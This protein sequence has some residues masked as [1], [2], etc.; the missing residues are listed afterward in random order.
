MPN[1][2]KL[3]LLLYV[4]LIFTSSKVWALA[5]EA[6]GQARWDKANPIL[7][8][9]QALQH[10]TDQIRQKAADY[11]TSQHR[12]RLTRSGPQGHDSLDVYPTGA[13]N[14]VRVIEE[15]IKKK[16]LYLTVVGDIELYMDC[17]E[18]KRD[19][20]HHRTLA[21][22]HFP[23]ERPDEANT[24]YLHDIQF[25]F[26]NLLAYE[27]G[28]S[29]YFFNAVDIGLIN[30]VENPV[31]APARLLPEGS[32]TTAL[33]HSEQFNV[34]YLVS[35]VIRSMALHNPAQPREPNL[36]VDLYN[37]SSLNPGFHNRNFE[38][39]VF[40]HDAFT[41]ALISQKRYHMTGDW[42]LDPHIRAGFESPQFWQQDYGKKMREVIRVISN[43]IQL[44]LGCEPI[45]ARI[46]QTQ[47]ESVWINTGTDSGLRQGDKLRVYRRMTHYDSELRPYFELRD[48]GQLLTLEDVQ[49]TMSRGRLPADSNT[50]NI[51]QDDIVIAH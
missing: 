5:F 28:R 18:E 31:Q 19:L 23:L 8:R 43:D 49:P 15:N 25:K 45:R 37:R 38:L 29:S 48:T 22:T 26:S 47:Q 20:P 1:R 3:H 41:G 17:N 14:N 30:L 39:D 36:L 21:V 7:S 40:V 16:T 50:L 12:E 42:T 32:I 27:L 24:G 51:Q 13:V 4:A 6:T 11:M 10:A 44:L 35:G 34:Q 33:H 9:E 2:S 46:T